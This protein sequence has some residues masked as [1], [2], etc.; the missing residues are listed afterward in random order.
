MLSDPQTVTINSVAKVM[1]RINQD[2]NSSV[3]R[4]RS[5]LDEYVLT[6]KHSNG[7]IVG[8]QPGEGHLAKLDYT[9]FATA[10]APE[11]HL[12]CWAVL[13]NPDGFDLTLSRNTMLG[14]MGYLSS[15]NIDKL[16][17]GES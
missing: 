1:P 9:V 3:Y 14:L 16:L 11:L 15:A 7:K 5:S 6:I 17:N 8:G 2:N 10:T 4:L 12:A 13:Q